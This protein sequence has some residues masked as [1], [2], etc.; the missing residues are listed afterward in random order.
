M[1]RLIMTTVFICAITA[2]AHAQVDPVSQFGVVTGT[3]RSITTRRANYTNMTRAI[4]AALSARQTLILP[5][6]SIEIEVPNSAP[7]GFRI[8]AGGTLHI[9]GQGVATS[10]L[11]FYPDNPTYNYDAF[12]LDPRT[13][14]V[15]KD[16]SIVGPSNPGPNGEFNR[17]TNAIVQSGQ[18]GTNYAVPY[19]IR[20]ERVNIE[21]EF[22]TAIRGN[23]GDGPLELIDCDLTAFHQVIAWQATFNAGKSIYARNSYFHDAGLPGKGHLIYPSP[24]VSLDFEG[25]R[26][27][28]NFRRAIHHYGSSNIRPAVVRIVNC[29]IEPT[30]KD[31]IETTGAGLTEIDRC[32]FNN[33]GIGIALK[34]DANISNSTFNGAGINTYDRHTNVTVNIVNCR[35]NRAGISA[36]PLWTDCNWNILDSS[37]I[38]SQIAINQAAVRTSLNVERCKFEGQSKRGIVMYNG[39]TTVKDSTFTANY[40]EGAV[41][42]ETTDIAARLCVLNTT[43]TGAGRGVWLKK[44]PAG[45]ALCK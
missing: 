5:A 28:G 26:F 9:T 13:F 15:F 4:N 20:L 25:C 16:F 30:C 39:Q 3:G 40:S 31:G 32:N 14:I 21:G 42:I 33:S 1:R 27:G 35:F 45:F 18:A 34:G 19:S 43:F 23:A 7:K 17:V 22:Y 36:S 37:F 24:N 10:K 2:L 41:I 44:V 12:K 6:D 38:D 29:T 11:R 8:K